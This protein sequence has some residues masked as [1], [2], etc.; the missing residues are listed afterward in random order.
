MYDYK[1]DPLETENKINTESYEKVKAT[2]QL[3]AARYFN[4]HVIK[5]TTVTNTVKK[6]IKN[7]NVINSPQVI[8]NPKVVNQEEKSSNLLIGATLNYREL[9][10]IKEKLFLKD[11]NYLTPAN[12][13]KQSRVHPNPSVWN[14][15]QI[16]DFVKFSKKHDLEVRLHGPI[17]PQASKWAKQDYRTADEL[18]DMMIEFT[19]AFAKKFNNEPTIKW[20]DVVNETILPNGKWF[21]PKEGTNKW[22]NPC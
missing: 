10:T 19:T 6:S 1:K 3:L 15:E 2:F 18:K 7:N 13:A 9:N 14:W 12:A 22:E 16:D 8:S 20:M 21:G 4:D 11:F 5:S 17:S